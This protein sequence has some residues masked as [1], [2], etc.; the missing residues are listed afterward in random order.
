MGCDIHMIAER[1]SNY[2]SNSEWEPIL[3]AIFKDRLYDVANEM[4]HWN[5]PYTFQPYT[6]RNY[7]LFSVLANVRNGGGIKPIDEPRGYPD[8][9]HNVSKWL[10]DGWDFADHSYTWLL[11]DEVLGYDWKQK[12]PYEG[13]PETLADI[14]SDFIN[15]M[16]T[17]ETYA[18]SDNDTVRLVFGFDN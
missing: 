6:D 17:L 3:D 7:A 13:E 15:N 16:K 14:C 9:M 8:D 18:K 12:S 2:E 10:L 5:A 4:S 1:K 11:L